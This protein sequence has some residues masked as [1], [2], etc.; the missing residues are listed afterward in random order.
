V[1]NPKKVSKAIL[2]V[3]E[4]QLRNLDPP[5]TRETLDRLINQGVAED[6]ARRLIGCVVASE[7]FD[8]LKHKQPFDLERYIMALRRLPELPWQN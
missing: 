2:D 5:A 4:N 8:I 7:I 3:V 6:E 1:P